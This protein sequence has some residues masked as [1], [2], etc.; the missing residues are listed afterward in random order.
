MANDI[1]TSAEVTAQ[2]SSTDSYGTP[3]KGC[4]SDDSGTPAQPM[5]PIHLTVAN[6]DA[7]PSP[8]T[9]LQS[10]GATVPEESPNV[11]A[12]RA[13]YQRTEDGVHRKIPVAPAPLPTHIAFNYDSDDG[14]D[15]DGEIEPFFDAV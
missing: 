2:F 3:E 12:F 1:C 9:V 4:H 6:D 11:K 15:F 14:A 13:P 7:H 8:V 10:A 5:P